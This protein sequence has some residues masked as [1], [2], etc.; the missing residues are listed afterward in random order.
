LTDQGVIL[1]SR[2]EILTLGPDVVVVADEIVVMAEA[3]NVSESRD[4]A[5]VVL[6][7]RA[8]EANYLARVSGA[9][10]SFS[11]YVNEPPPRLHA[12]QR[13]LKHGKA[14]VPYGDY[15]DLRAILTSFRST[16]HSG[17]SVPAD[18]FHRYVMRGG[19]NRDRILSALT[20][21]GVIRRA[22]E[23]YLL[24]SGALGEIGFSLLEVKR[25]TP[26]D[27]VLSFLAQTRFG[28]TE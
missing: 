2:S 20:A 13:A 1:G 28:E 17:L 6:A 10:A 4:G 27:E 19:D 5:G 21:R 25:G 11:L 8:L 12:F 3:L 22:G 24:D 14:F 26:G 15:V 23:Y 7:S 9:T 18:R 16:V